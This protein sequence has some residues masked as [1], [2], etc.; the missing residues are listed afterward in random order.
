[1]TQKY[2]FLCKQDYY[3]SISYKLDKLITIEDCDTI[4]F[5]YFTEYVF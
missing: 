3:G 1:M 2:I 5:C 4:E